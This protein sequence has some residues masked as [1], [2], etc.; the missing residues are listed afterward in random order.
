MYIDH[1]L[2]FLLFMSGFS[3]TWIFLTDFRQTRGCADKSLARPRRKQ[4]TATKLGIYSTHA[5]RSSIHFSVRSSNST[6][7]FHKNL[8]SGG[9]RVVTCGRTDSGTHVT[10]LTVVSRNF[11]T[12]LKKGL[13]I[14][15]RIASKMYMSVLEC[16]FKSDGYHTYW[17]EC[18]VN[19]I[20]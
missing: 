8:S 18:A 17:Q 9:S 19:F 1:Y 7:K 20:K 4:A 11:A 13:E 5:P 3:E 16:R 12:A 10:N 15:I 2:K 14:T 6:T